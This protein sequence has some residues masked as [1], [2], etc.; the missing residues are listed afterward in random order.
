MG[1][2]VS[3]LVSLCPDRMQLDMGG[4]QEE[5]VIHLL[6]IHGKLLHIIMCVCVGVG[7]CGCVKFVKFCYLVVLRQDLV[8]AVRNHIRSLNWGHRVKL[9]EK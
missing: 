2:H 6:L 5:M 1:V 3:C 7:V 8:G 9:N 4:A